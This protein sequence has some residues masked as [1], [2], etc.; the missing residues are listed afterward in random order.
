MNWPRSE[1]EF[2]GVSP[3]RFDM[4]VLHGALHEALYEVLHEVLY[5]ALREAMYF[6]RKAVKQQICWYWPYSFR[7]LFSRAHLARPSH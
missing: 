1:G 4:E 7:S 3:L 2:K 6:R 5:K